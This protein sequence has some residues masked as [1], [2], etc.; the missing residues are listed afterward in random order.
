MLTLLQLLLPEVAAHHRVTVLVDA[1]GEVVEDYFK[2]ELKRLSRADSRVTKAI[3]HAKRAAR[4]TFQVTGS[5]KA[6]G[7][8][9]TLDGHHLFSKSSRPDL[10]NLHENILI[11]ESS[12]HADF[13]G[14][15]SRRGAKCEPKDFLEYLSGARFDLIDPSNSAA[16]VRH[17]SL[18]ERLVILRISYEGNRLRYA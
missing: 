6:R 9:L 12:I 8:Q 17:N 16:A 5:R 10:A 1:L 7:R 2:K 18:T 3:K 14:W 11:L 4:D 15:Q 13:H